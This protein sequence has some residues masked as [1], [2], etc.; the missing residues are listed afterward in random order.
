MCVLFFI[1]SLYNF[2]YS[3]FIA[4]NFYYNKFIYLDFNMFW[5]LKNF[6]TI[7]LL[8]PVFGIIYFI[9][10][11]IV[12][13]QRWF[14]FDFPMMLKNYLY[15]HSIF[16]RH[17]LIKYSYPLLKSLERARFIFCSPFIYLGNSVLDD[18]LKTLIFTLLVLLLITLQR[19]LMNLEFSI[20]I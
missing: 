17:L 10:A 11:N 14:N 6:V 2:A 9:Y 20:Q 4:P 13:Y 19:N 5:D 8:Q 15:V 1:G 7:L 18:D 12:S 3:L 16:V